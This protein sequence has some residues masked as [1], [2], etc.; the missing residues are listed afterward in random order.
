[1]D[2]R[3]DEINGDFERWYFEN[4]HSYNRKRIAIHRLYYGVL[5]WA[6]RFTSFDLLDGKDKRA[7]DVGC[8]HGY[9][10]ELLSHLGYIACGCDIS[11]LY[12]RRYAKN[13]ARDLVLCDAHKLAFHGASFDL[14]T[15]FE[16]LEHLENQYEFL[17]NCFESLKPE[18]ALVL[19]TP[20]GIPS[21]DGA[22][23]KIYA[24]AVLGSNSVEHHISTITHQSVLSSLLNRCGFKSRIETWFLLP[25]SPTIFD[26]YFPTKI[27]IAVPTFRVVAV[28]RC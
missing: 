10:V 3:T 28:K 11:R 6:R 16:L 26:R 8:A 12:L 15:A 25:L 20:R 19:Q 17:R 7:L 5:S 24:R 4:W 1:M 18:G 22:L 14:I 23:S 9:T 27:P 2:Y 13:V 21:V